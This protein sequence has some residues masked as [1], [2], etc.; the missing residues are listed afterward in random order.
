MWGTLATANTYRFSSKEIDPQSG[1]YCYG[2]RYYEPNLQRW[3]NRDPIQERGGINL[4]DY[5]GNNPVNHIDPLG[6]DFS[7]WIG[8]GAGYSNFINDNSK[9]QPPPANY[10]TPNPTGHGMIML[11]SSL[12]AF[13]IV[14]GGG[15][16]QTILL[17]N[18]QVV[19]YGYA[20][21]GTGLGAKLPRCKL[22]SLL[23]HRVEG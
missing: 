23:T 21:L 8:G 18:G 20:M 17:D 2:Y 15:G 14:G 22:T 4:Y 11:D 3:L 1:I 5:V 7:L 10:S 9:P 16:T 6:L 19:S 13:G 12:S